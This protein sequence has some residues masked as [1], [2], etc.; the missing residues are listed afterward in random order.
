VTQV[1][2]RTVLSQ[3]GVFMLFYD[4]VDPNSVLVSDLDKSDGVERA[5]EDADMPDEAP[6]SCLVIQSPSMVQQ[7]ELP[8]TD[9]ESDSSMQ[10]DG[11]LP[12]PGSA[13][14]TSEPSETR[15]PDETVSLP[16][17]LSPGP[18]EPAE[19]P[20]PGIP[21]LDLAEDQNM[22]QASADSM[23]QPMD[24]PLLPQSLARIPEV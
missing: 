1:D 17:A 10:L 7:D 3:G 14:V 18:E 24:G 4:C 5:P 2:E 16:Q 12:L 8:S 22:G 19:R 15:A 23:T 9:A 21:T 13:T 6:P 20:I 11:A